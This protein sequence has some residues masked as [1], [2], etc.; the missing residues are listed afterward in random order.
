MP[1]T[2]ITRAAAL[3]QEQA[4][5]YARLDAA[6]VHLTQVLVSG[7]PGQIESLTR[8]GESE[9]MRMRSRLFEITKA[10]SLF[11]DARA[12]ASDANRPAP[13]TP[14]AR[15]AFEAAS[16]SLLDAARA[17]ERTQKHA[18]AIALNGSTF[19]A[20][21]LLVCGVPPMTYRAPYSRREN[22]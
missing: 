12:A 6:C 14:E 5:A 7:V 16:A 4:A 20:S 22:F 21:C 18:A 10:L 1:D 3:M 8:A 2:H 19:A 15:A 9:L 11:A 17:F 13:V